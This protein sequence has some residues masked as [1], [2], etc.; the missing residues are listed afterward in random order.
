MDIKLVEEL[1]AVALEGV[2]SITEGYVRCTKSNEFL[3]SQVDGLI[4]TKSAVEIELAAAKSQLCKIEDICKN[5][6][7]VPEIPYHLTSA[8]AVS[9]VEFMSDKIIGVDHE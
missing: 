8:S 5:H 1:C 3:K 9:G 4:R 2:E 6:G 7:Y